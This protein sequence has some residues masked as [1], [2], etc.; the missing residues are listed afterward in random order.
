MRVVLTRESGALRWRRQGEEVFV[1]VT[2]M[3]D[4]DAPKAVELCLAT[5]ANSDADIEAAVRAHYWS[6][7]IE[8]SERA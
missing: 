3:F 4:G 6:A 7:A 8:I 1:P 2:L 5:D